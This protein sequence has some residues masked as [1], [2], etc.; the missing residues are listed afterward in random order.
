MKLKFSV[1][2][3]GSPI[4]EA[5]YGVTD[6]ESFGAAC[7]DIWEKLNQR[8]IAGAKSIGALYES[9]EDS[10]AL[11]LRGLRIDLEPLDP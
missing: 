9:L 4:C 8:R 5:I 7:S 1:T 3:Y 6:A 10:R 11:E 2:R